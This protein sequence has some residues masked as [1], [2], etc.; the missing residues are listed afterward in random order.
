VVDAGELMRMVRAEGLDAPVLDGV[1]RLHSDAVVLD[2]DGGSW[3]VHLV[4]ERG[5]VIESTRGT[6][7]TESEALE[8]VLLKL[9]QVAAA[10]RSLAALAD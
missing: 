3:T 6:F 7:D 4:D 5:A 8:R 1:G 2:R 9:R 10:R